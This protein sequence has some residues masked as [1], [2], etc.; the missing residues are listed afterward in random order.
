MRSASYAMHTTRAHCKEGCICKRHTWKPSAA[1]RARISAW[2]QAYLDTL[3]VHYNKGRR[4][5]EGCIQLAREAAKLR[6]GPL[7]PFYGKRHSAESIAR[8]SAVK[9]GKVSGMKGKTGFPAWNKGLTKDTDARVRQSNEHKTRISG[10]RRSSLGRKM[11]EVCLANRGVVVPEKR[12]GTYFVDAYLPAEHLA[13]EA[14]GTYWHN[15][16]GAAERDAK[17]DQFL[18]AE[19]GLRVI[20]LPQEEIEA[21]YAGRGA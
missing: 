10:G 5:S 19:F 12:F 7:N 17:R 20:R 18:L 9:M 2:R 4:P 21:A 6:V 11:I 13:Y 8:M 16:P 1:G 3:A 15:R 14:D